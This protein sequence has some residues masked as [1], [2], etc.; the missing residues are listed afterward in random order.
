MV[1][2]K[3]SLLACAFYVGLVVLVNAVLLALAQ[4]S[5]VGF[6]IDGPGLSLG[7][8]YGVIFGTLWLISFSAAWWIVYLGLKS[9]LANFSN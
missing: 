6:R 9:R 1:F 3:L 7:A 4:F 2:F 5:P 8:R